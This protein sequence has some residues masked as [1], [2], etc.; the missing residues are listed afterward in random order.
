MNNQNENAEQGNWI[1]LNRSI[2]DW[3][4]FQDANTLQVFMYLLL[5]A[6][7]KDGRWKG[8]EVKR[9][10]HITSLDK[11]AS[12][13]SLS[14]QQV[15][16]C[17]S[18]LQ[19]TQEINTQSNTHFTLVTI[20]KY[21]TYQG[22]DEK[23]N[24]QSNIP[25]TFHQHSNN[26]QI[27]L[28][29]NDKEGK[30]QKEFSTTTTGDQP[31]EKV[32]NSF[33]EIPSD[34]MKDYFQLKDVISR[35]QSFT[36]DKLDETAL[37]FIKTKFFMIRNN[38]FTK[39]SGEVWDLL[40]FTNWLMKLL[41]EEGYTFN[42]KLQRPDSSNAKVFV[43]QNQSSVPAPFTKD[44]LL[45][46]ISN[47]PEIVK[48][49]LLSKYDAFQSKGWKTSNGNTVDLTFFTGFLRD[50]VRKALNITQGSL[51][52]NEYDPKKL[53]FGKDFFKR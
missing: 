20:C 14:K 51:Q 47:E 22:E 4:W 41:S 49:E 25:S 11:I 23:S 44:T 27:T 36:N 28:N 50:E 24:T 52:Y 12:G 48:Q 8:I 18:K 45:Q 16:T 39:K 21:D 38:A 46:V 5:K 53:N 40:S 19:K 9:G 35:I 42:A 31:T 17:L 37:S 26:I 7:H 3:E 33:E 10:Q 15:R 2:L 43:P 29:K 32:G 13:C 1:K 34:E 6:N 30:E